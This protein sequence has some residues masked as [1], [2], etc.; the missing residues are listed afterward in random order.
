MVLL[1]TYSTSNV[2]KYVVAILPS[3]LEAP[4]TQK[5]ALNPNMS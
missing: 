3:R 4:T 1:G 2:K 5:Y